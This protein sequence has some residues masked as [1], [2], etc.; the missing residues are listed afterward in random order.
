MTLTLPSS[1]LGLT[2]LVLPA[3]AGDDREALKFFENEIRHLLAAECYDCHGP[4]KA[5]AGLRLD[6]RE[7]MITGGDTGPALVPGKP[8]ESIMIGAVH[9]T[10]PDFAMP[11]KKELQPAQVA[12]LE[13]WVALGAPWPAEVA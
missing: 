13:K 7:F 9:R 1:L 2:L 5:K 8:A 6:H 3:F 12:A 11:P 4:E 10:D